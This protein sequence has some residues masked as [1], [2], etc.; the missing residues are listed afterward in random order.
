M[1]IYISFKTSSIFLINNTLRH[2]DSAFS[3]FNNKLLIDDIRN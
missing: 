3:I 2:C 1:A